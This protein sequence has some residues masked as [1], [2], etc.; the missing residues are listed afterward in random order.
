MLAKKSVEE[1]V[2]WREMFPSQ[3][4]H[5][6]QS[7][8]PGYQHPDGRWFLLVVGMVSWIKDS[9]TCLKGLL[10]DSLIFSI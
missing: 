7:C 5:Q 9:K 4:C 10:Y 2:V 8:P 1:L 6:G 3:Y